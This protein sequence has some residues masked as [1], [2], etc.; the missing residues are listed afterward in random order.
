MML[1]ASG[2]SSSIHRNAEES[3]SRKPT[4]PKVETYRILTQVGE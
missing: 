4:I 3:S 1:G 2:F